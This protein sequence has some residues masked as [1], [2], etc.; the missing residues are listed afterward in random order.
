MRFGYS[1]FLNWCFGG[2]LQKYYESYRWSGWE[3]EVTALP[4]DYA[5]SV[6][7]P[8]F[9]AGFPIGRRSRRA[10]PVE[11]MFELHAVVVPPQLGRPTPF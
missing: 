6:A 10:G 1:Q 9:T 5:L 11:Q 3:D 2:N 8:L 7:P 4:G